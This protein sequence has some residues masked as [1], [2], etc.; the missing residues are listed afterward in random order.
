MMMMMVV[1]KMCTNKNVFFFIITRLECF[2]KVI[3]HQSMEKKKFSRKRMTTLYVYISANWH[4]GKFLVDFC[5]ERRLVNMERSAIT[6]RQP[7]AYSLKLECRL[8][9]HAGSMAMWGRGFSG[10]FSQL[11]RIQF[12]LIRD[13]WLHELANTVFSNVC[14]LFQIGCQGDEPP[15]L[16]GEARQE[17]LAFTCSVVQLEFKTNLLGTRIGFRLRYNIAYPPSTGNVY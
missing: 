13:V 17:L 5:V 1:T 16:C 8:Q 14:S 7:I 15:K 12:P 11:Q 6:F 3:R 2:H 9:H 4:F 10:K